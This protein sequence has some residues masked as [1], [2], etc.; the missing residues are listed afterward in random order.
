[1]IFDMNKKK[2]DQNDVVPMTEVNRIAIQQKR[3]FPVDLWGGW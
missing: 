3:E 2:Q 1:M